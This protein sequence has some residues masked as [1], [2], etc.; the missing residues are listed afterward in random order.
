MSME[1][2]DFEHPAWLQE[3]KRI[4]ESELFFS[5]EEQIRA[6]NALARLNVEHR[7]G[8]PFGC[9]IVN[10][11]S[12]AVVGFGVNSV[13]ARGSL[14]HAET[15]AIWEAQRR[16]GHYD[17]GADPKVSYSLACNAAPCTMCLGAV[18]WSGVRILVTGASTADVE[19]ITGFDEGPQPKDLEDELRIRRIK[20]IPGVLSEEC[21]SVLQLYR[22]NGG[23][24]YNGGRG[25]R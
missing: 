18:I 21:R 10:S 13:V 20:W 1:R 22:R 23:Q 19:V 15:V 17:L 4:L 11:Q 25:F 16:L 8:G 24:V 6:A 5:A 9:V 2:L 12:G 3:H 7:T 14:F